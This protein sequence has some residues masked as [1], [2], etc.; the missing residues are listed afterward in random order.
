MSK[1]GQEQP[2]PQYA[3]EFKLE[4]IRLVKAGKNLRRSVDTRT[5]N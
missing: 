5:D 2:R 1:R 4:A 3:P